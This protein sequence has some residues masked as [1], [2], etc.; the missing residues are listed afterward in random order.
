MKPIYLLTIFFIFLSHALPAKDNK[1]LIAA[2]YYYRQL[3]YHEAIPFYEKIAGTLNDPTVFAQLGDCYRLTGNFP[4]AADWYARSVAVPGYKDATVM[5]YAQVL[6][7]LTKYEEAKKWLEEFSKNNKTDRRVLN[8]IAGCET[9]MVRE[10][11]AI[12][13][14][15]ASFMEFNSEGSEFAPTLWNGKLVFSADTA[16]GVKKKTDKWSGN[17]YFNIYSVTAD[18]N[19]ICGTDFSELVKGKDVNIKYHNGPCTFSAG[20][21]EMYYTRSRFNRTFFTKRSISNK[22]S[23][24]LL[25]I[26]FATDYDSS[27]K[28]FKTITP[29]A[30]NSKDYSVAH[31]AVSP[32]GNLLIFSSNMPK[33]TGGSDLYMCIKRRNKEWSK[34]VNI[35][36]TVNTEGE[37]LFPSWADSNTLYFSSDGHKGMGGMDIY[38]SRWDGK[39]QTFSA[40]ENVGL[41]INSS[42]DDISLA[43]RADG[44][45]AYFSSNRPAQK[46]GDNI[47]FFRKQKIFLAINIFDSVS[48]ARLKGATLKLTSIKDTLNATPEGTYYRQLYPGRQYSV[49]A[50][51]DEYRPKQITITANGGKDYD[52]IVN[53]VYLFKPEPPKKDTPKPIEPIVIRHRNVMDTPGIPEF[54]ENEVYEVGAFHYDYNKHTLTEKHKIFLDTLLTQLNRHPTLRI[55]IRA[56]TD[57]RGSQAFN[58]ILSDKRALSVLT[59]LVAHGIKRDRL[60]SIGLGSSAPT[61]PCPICTECTEEQHY[62]NRILDIKVLHL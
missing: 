53:N 24:V 35:G 3:A 49:T 38:V 17:P 5:H 20:G 56:H 57:C 21:K 39:T 50:D 40:P 60:E 48:G 62:V 26:M 14:G 7:Q 43:L 28:E 22:D 29:F 41:P 46:G 6:M 51:K 59:Y 13:E 34:P 33:G 55:Q 8:L 52:T 61:Y 37:E 23:L 44:G 54:V 42:Y 11:D 15:V 19:G 32:N 4:K 25:E 36:K 30:Y 18:A 2:N 1:D 9:A 10:K 12:P 27:K 47:Y 31:P 58:Q 45:N 16:I